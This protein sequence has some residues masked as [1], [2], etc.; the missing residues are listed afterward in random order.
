MVQLK[1][2]P[3]SFKSPLRKTSNKGLESFLFQLHSFLNQS[4]VKP[5]Q[6]VHLVAPSTVNYRYRLFFQAR[7]FEL[8]W[9]ACYTSTILAGNCIFLSPAENVPHTRIVW[10]VWWLEPYAR[11]TCVIHR[12]IPREV[13]KFSK[14]AS[15]S[16]VSASNMI[17]NCHQTIKNC[18]VVCF[19]GGRG[20][21]LIGLTLQ[22][23]IMSSLYQER[24]NHT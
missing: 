9:E 21:N 1:K 13:D 19:G 17:E 22:T 5:C 18:V 15:I 12:N 16:S 2:L 23:L 4:C 20:C 3:E 24:V 10:L 11:S 8:S 7:N 6:M 14:N